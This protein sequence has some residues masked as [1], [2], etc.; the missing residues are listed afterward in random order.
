ML[1]GNMTLVRGSNQIKLNIVALPKGL[2]VIHF[3][4]NGTLQKLKFLKL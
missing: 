4:N 1:Q 2:Y 3:E